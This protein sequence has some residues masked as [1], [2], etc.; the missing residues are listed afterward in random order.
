MAVRCLEVFEYGELVHLAED[1]GGVGRSLLAR[2]MNALGPAGCGLLAVRGVP[3][4][5]SSRQALLPLARFLA[6]LSPLQRSDILKEHG[7][8]TDVSFKDPDRLV[9]SFAAQL[10]FG[11]KQEHTQVASRDGAATALERKDT[12]SNPPHYQVNNWLAEKGLHELGSHFR[13]LGEAMVEV[14]LLMARICDMA[15]PGIKLEE[16]ILEASTAKGRLI[17]YHSLVDRLLL[18]DILSKTGSKAR[19]ETKSNQFKRDSMMN[20]AFSCKDLWQQW[21]F[22]YGIFTVLTVPMFMSICDMDISCLESAV[23]NFLY[24][25]LKSS[26]LVENAESDALSRHIGLKVLNSGNGCVEFVNVPADCLIIQVGEAAQILTGGKLRATAHCVC[27]PSERSDISRETF[28][29][30]LQP[31]WNKRLI[32]PKPVINPTIHGHDDENLVS[33][34]PITSSTFEKEFQEIQSKV[35][36]LESRWKDG[37]TFVEFSRETTKQYYGAN[38]AQSKK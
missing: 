34:I 28:V 25:E 12:H 24:A 4:L 1:G 11:Q 7:L 37:S 30:F 15:I 18:R 9:S 8:G 17:H 38:G 5:L 20:E 32:L 33:G 31:A 13:Q 35:P 23:D 6:L 27:R 14:G 21:H 10:S 22:D 16:A 19:N 29:V 26:L 2:F 3:N 36:A